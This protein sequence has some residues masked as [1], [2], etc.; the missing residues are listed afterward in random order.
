M[1]RVQRDV[2][3]RHRRPKARPAGA[4][5]EFGLGIEKRL[6][7][8]DAMINAVLFRVPI[9]AAERAFGSLASCDAKLLRSHQFAPFRLS[10]F[11]PYQCDGLGQS[12]RGNGLL[13]GQRSR[14]DGPPAGQFLPIPGVRRRLQ[15]EPLHPRDGQYFTG[16]DAPEPSVSS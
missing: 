10:L 3:R 15:S 16:V 1:V 5:I 6:P 8:A 11:E 13:G 12:I 4:G 2:V 14:T 7:A 9:D